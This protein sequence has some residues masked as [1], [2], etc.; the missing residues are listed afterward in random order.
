MRFLLVVALLGQ[1][2]APP[3]D[4]EVFLAPL[5]VRGSKVEI[6]TPI[7]ISSNPGYDNQPSFTP[8]GK[9]VL[10]TSVRGERKP[11]PANSAATGSDIYRYDIVDGRLSQV[12]NTSEAEYSPTV[13]DRKSVV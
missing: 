12:T 10:F 11:N 5:S 9:A 2:P 7:N 8:D 1:A 6:G 4:T 13:T 3:P